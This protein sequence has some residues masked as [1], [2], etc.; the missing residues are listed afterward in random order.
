[1]AHLQ[2]RDLSRKE[3]DRQRAESGRWEPGVNR[4]RSPGRAP[5]RDPW[6]D[7]LASA[8]DSIVRRSRASQKQAAWDLVRY[9][10]TFL[11]ILAG[12]L[13]L[14]FRAL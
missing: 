7:R 5:Q 9:L 6:M 14:L 4:G 10:A 12:L 2:V 3:T 1:M 8:P 13:V 11:A